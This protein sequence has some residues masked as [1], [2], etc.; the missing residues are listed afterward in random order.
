MNK[1]PFFIR[2]NQ[3]ERKLLEEI[4]CIEVRCQNEIIVDALYLYEIAS[5]NMDIKQY[6]NKECKENNNGKIRKY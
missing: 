5:R 1:I 2:F 4:S 6:L 3:R